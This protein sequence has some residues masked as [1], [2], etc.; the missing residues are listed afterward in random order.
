MS[1]EDREGAMQVKEENTPQSWQAEAGL[2]GLRTT[3]ERSP[4]C[5]SEVV[6]ENKGTRVRKT[7]GRSCR[8]QGF[9]VTAKTCERHVK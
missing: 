4:P 1:Q 6:E 2:V 9:V 3:Q 5:W 7:K 8:W